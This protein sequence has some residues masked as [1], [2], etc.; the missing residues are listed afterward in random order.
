MSTLGQHQNSP[1]PFDVGGS[2]EAK[3]KDDS[4]AIRATFTPSNTIAFGIFIVLLI[5]KYNHLCNL[6]TST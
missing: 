1:L 6:G 4:L 3:L 5:Y 2:H